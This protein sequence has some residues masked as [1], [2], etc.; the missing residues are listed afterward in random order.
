[1]MAGSS[2][3]RAPA[4]VTIAVGIAQCVVSDDPKA[5]LVSYGLGSCVGIA[6]WD[7]VARVAGLIHILLPE[8]MSHDRAPSPTRFAATGI[9]HLVG[10]LT[11]AGAVP[12][13]LRVV[14]AGGAQMLAA[15]AIGGAAKGIGARNVEVVQATLEQVGLRL[16]AH[17][18]GGSSG[19]TIGLSVATGTAWVRAAGGQSRDL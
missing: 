4:D 15:L 1:M 9:P 16:V 14:A 19:R 18:F 13:R 8:P 5:M 10:E 12:S 7:P 2:A 17:D 3:L 11:A 6:A